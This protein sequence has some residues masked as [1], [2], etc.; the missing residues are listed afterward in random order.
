VTCLLLGFAT[1]EVVL[2]SASPCPCVALCDFL[3]VF[4]LVIAAARRP[5]SRFGRLSPVTV[6][7]HF[8]VR[9]AQI[10]RVIKLVHSMGV[11]SMKTRGVEVA[12]VRGLSGRVAAEKRTGAAAAVV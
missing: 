8:G 7:D 5:V 4:C 10:D 2:E 12:L 11:A 6:C 3:F 9:G 1:L